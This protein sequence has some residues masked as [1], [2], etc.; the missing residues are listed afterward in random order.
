MVG[1]ND[2]AALYLEWESFGIRINS[3]STGA[4]SI[5]TGIARR[6]TSL[7]TWR[8]LETK[9]KYLFV[10]VD[11]VF[12]VVFRVVLRQDKKSFPYFTLPLHSLFTLFLFVRAQGNK[13]QRKK[14]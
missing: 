13:K 10:A 14:E 9:I 8:G 4:K 3:H 1:G 6:Y 5:T 12:I 2:K 7:F 11:V